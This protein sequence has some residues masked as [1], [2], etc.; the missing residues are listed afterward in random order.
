MLAKSFIPSLSS[1]AA[2]TVACGPSVPIPEFSHAAA[3]FRCAPV[4]QAGTA[5][6]LA[7]HPINPAQPPSPYV[8]V[9]IWETVA[10]LA[11]RSW[12]MNTDTAGAWY[13]V[14]GDGVVS[15]VAG[16]V[17]VTSVD[18]AKSVKGAVDLQFPWSVV[19][20]FNA[21]WINNGVTCP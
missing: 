5:I 16:S 12:S 19:T 11:G 7:N 18:P 14:G 2:I 9:T 6:V 4:D 1:I 10:A 21:P 8:Q 13:V 3:M 17:T 20:E 15:A